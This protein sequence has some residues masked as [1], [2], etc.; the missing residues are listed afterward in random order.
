MD[1]VKDGRENW[2]CCLEL[3]IEE[4]WFNRRL[5]YDFDEEELQQISE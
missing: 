3:G 2:I 4:I 1:E 5:L